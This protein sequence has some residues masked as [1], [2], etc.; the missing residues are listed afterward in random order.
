MILA[1]LTKIET[2]AKNYSGE[3]TTIT[4]TVTNTGSTVWQGTKSWLDEIWV[5]PDPV[6][7][8]RDAISGIGRL[9]LSGLVPHNNETTLKA[10][11][12]YTQSHTFN[13]PPGID[14]EYFVYISTAYPYSLIDEY[15]P[16]DLVAGLPKFTSVNDQIRNSY[17]TR[18]YE[19]PIDSLTRGTI[20]VTYREADLRISRLDVPTVARAGETLDLA[21]SV[22]NIG[23]RDTRVRQWQDGFYLSRDLSV[24]NLDLQLGSLQH[25]NQLNK[26]SSYD[27]KLLVDLPEDLAAGEY[28]LIAEADSGGAGNVSEYAGEG[29][30]SKYQKIRID[31]A[32]TADLKVDRVV[33][34][35]RAIAGQD[36]AVEY[37][38]INQGLLKTRN[39]WTDTV[40][41]SRDQYLNNLVLKYYLI[42]RSNIAKTCWLIYLGTGLGLHM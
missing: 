22:E 12:S 27:G 26:Y 35:G 7:D 11:E 24:D 8:E 29:N 38:V 41:L 42:H 14:G 5:S 18:V 25:N 30:N 4:W 9:K 15:S 20:Q 10:G 16:E 3:P 31:P 17:K 32:I 33:V 40:Y 6:F 39:V 36:F 37:T 23:S 2:L 13:L 34:P 19:N 21:W 28:Y 1:K